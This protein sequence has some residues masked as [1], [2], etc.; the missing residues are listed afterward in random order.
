MKLTYRLGIHSG[1]KTRIVWDETMGHAV[2]I[3]YQVERITVDTSGI[4]DVLWACS[5]PPRDSKT[6]VY[7]LDAICQAGIQFATKDTRLELLWFNAT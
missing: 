6:A 4:P 5:L 7:M 2:G 1:V 3:R